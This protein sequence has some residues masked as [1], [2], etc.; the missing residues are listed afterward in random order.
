VVVERGRFPRLAC[1]L[2]ASVWHRRRRG[3]EC[4]DVWLNRLPEREVAR[5]IT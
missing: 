4:R 1:A 3:L 2:T 5:W